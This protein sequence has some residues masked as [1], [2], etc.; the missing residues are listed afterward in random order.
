[1]DGVGQGFL[2]GPVPWA[3]WLFSPGTASC[4]NLP[5]EGN[6]Q[7]PF[8]HQQGPPKLKKR[9]LESVCSIGCGSVAGHGA[10]AEY[11]AS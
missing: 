10:D 11:L 7:R 3:D 1:M 5:A 2:L 8:T 4:M 6:S 9:V